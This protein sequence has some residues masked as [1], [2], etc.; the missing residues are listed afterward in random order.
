MTTMAS[1][2]TMPT[3]SVNARSERL[4][5]VKPM[6]WMMAN[7]AIIEVGIDRAAM[8]VARRLARKKNTMIAAK[9][10]PMIKWC[11]TASTEVSM[12]TDWS[13]TIFTS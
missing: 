3:A 5:S 8:I 9:P 12:K 4:L 6:Y 7:V 13:P 2:M 1:S 11:S 10:P